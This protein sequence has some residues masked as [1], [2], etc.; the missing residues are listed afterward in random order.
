LRPLRPRRPPFSPNSRWLSL[1]RFVAPPHQVFLTPPLCMALPPE[2]TISWP[3]LS[4]FFFFPP[5]VLFFF[6]R[7]NFGCFPVDSP[8][9]V[10]CSPGPSPSPVASPHSFGEFPP[11]VSP[12][13]FFF[14]CW[15]ATSFSA[16]SFCTFFFGVFFHSPL[17]VA[18]LN[19]CRFLSFHPLVVRV[20]PCSFHAHTLFF[21]PPLLRFFL[22]LFFFPR[23]LRGVLAPSCTP[24]NCPP[25]YLEHVLY[26]RRPFCQSFFLAYSL[27]S[28]RKGSGFTPFVTL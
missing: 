1:L 17:L 27:F 28:R 11:P 18:Y 25:Y 12:H 5:S 19:N 6:F 7:C 15:W 24:S 21:S 14:A 20:L 3:S 26:A 13:C 9:R 23:F 22:L 10:V 4:S 8:N 2:N 16:V